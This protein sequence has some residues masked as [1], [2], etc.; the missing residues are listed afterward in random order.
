MLTKTLTNTFTDF[1]AGWEKTGQKFSDFL[2]SFAEENEATFIN[3]G[4][5]I[6]DKQVIKCFFPELQ[7]GGAR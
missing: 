7:A 6:I 3:M 1:T 2:A 4:A 5:L